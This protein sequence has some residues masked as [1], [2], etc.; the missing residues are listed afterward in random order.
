[1]CKKTDVWAIGVMAFH[2]FTDDYP[3]YNP[4]MNT[5]FKEILEK[6]VDLASIEHVAGECA[7]DFVGRLLDK[8]PGTR[9]CV[10][11]ALEHP[12]LRIV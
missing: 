5:T 12:W 7:A 8:D 4:N 1:V 10:D 11:E 2:A 3:F 6:N 9:M